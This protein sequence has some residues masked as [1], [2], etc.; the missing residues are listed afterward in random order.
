MAEIL[1]YQANREQWFLLIPPWQSP[2]AFIKWPTIS[3]KSAVDWV[4][5]KSKNNAD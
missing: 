2:F 3:Q 5:Y 4:S 1:V